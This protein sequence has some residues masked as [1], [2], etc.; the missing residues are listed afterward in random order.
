MH[1]NAILQCPVAVKKLKRNDQMPFSV[2]EEFKNEVKQ[3]ASLNNDYIVKLLGVSLDRSG[4]CL[5]PY[6]FSRAC[7]QY[8]LYN[9]SKLEFQK[10]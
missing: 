5:L 9:Y 10:H 1:F 4:M 2:I 6:H 8:V 7:I 3:M